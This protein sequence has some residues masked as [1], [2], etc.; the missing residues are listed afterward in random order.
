MTARSM[1]LPVRSAARD[2]GRPASYWRRTLALLRTWRQRFRGRE[3]LALLDNR[4][5]RDIGLTRCD[6]LWEASKPFWR[7]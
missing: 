7:E 6:A 5:L 2:C 4:S 3:E 1:A